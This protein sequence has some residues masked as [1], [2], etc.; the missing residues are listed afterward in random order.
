MSREMKT[1]K[2]R[3]ETTGTAGRVMASARGR[4]MLIDSSPARSAKEAEAMTSGDLF[5]SSLIGCG[6]VIVDA[7]ARKLDIPMKMAVFEAETVRYA[8][9]LSRY[10]N[11]NIEVEIEGVSQAEAETLVKAYQDDCPIYRLANEGSEVSMKV[12]TK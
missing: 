10:I 11:I 3:T 1:A 2:A 6:A 4:V 9:D 8:D 5:I 7:T 12:T